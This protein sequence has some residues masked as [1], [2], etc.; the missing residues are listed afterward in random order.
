METVSSIALVVI[1]LLSICLIGVVFLFTIGIIDYYIVN[2][3][4]IRQR[5][6]EAQQRRKMLLRMRKRGK[7]G[8]SR[9]TP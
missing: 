8:N 4:S 1:I 5:I 3:V 7:I 2:G 6:R 9:G